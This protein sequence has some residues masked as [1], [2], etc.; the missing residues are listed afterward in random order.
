MYILYKRLSTMIVILLSFLIIN[1]SSFQEVS[2]INKEEEFLK[3]VNKEKPLDKTYV[4]KDLCIVSNV[5]FIMRADETMYINKEVLYYYSLLYNDAISKGLRL[6][7][8]SGYRS[9]AKQE[10]LWHKN[11]NEFYVAKPGYSEHQTGLAIDVSR[12]DIGL[13]KNFENTEEYKYLKRHAHEF[14]FIVRYP[15]E[16]Q[17]ITGY[18]FEPWHLRY[19]GIENATNI[20]KNNLTLEE[21]L[22]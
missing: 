8:F 10:I 17:K 16:K 20:Y 22:S 18:L 1:K 13:T 7:I 14:G 19:V 5:D 15:K 21:Y 11:P 2:Y 6:T 12:R 3:L 9:Y 4:P